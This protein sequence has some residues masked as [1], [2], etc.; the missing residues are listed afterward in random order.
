M[1]VSVNCTPPA[2]AET[3]SR[4]LMVGVGMLMGNVVDVDALPPL[5]V[6]VILAL[7]GLAI[8]LAVTVAVS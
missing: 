7:P 4:L 1:T 2:V 6:T 8:R 3:G 5:F